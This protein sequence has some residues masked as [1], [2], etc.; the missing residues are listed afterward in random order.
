M[1]RPG[2]TVC[3]FFLHEGEDLFESGKETWFA[4]RPEPQHKL[5]ARHVWGGAL[6]PS[7]LPEGSEGKDDSTGQ[8]A[9]QLHLLEDFVI[10]LSRTRGQGQP[11]PASS[12]STYR[13]GEVSRATKSV[14]DEQGAA[15]CREGPPR[16][17]TLG[18]PPVVEAWEGGEGGFTNDVVQGEMGPEEIHKP[19]MKGPVTFLFEA[20]GDVV[21]FPEPMWELQAGVTGRDQG[22][23]GTLDTVGP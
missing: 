19:P 20:L 15:L 10:L 8:G 16:E 3:R 14:K 7:P 6:P 18:Q 13:R 23:A 5:I 2:Q 17:V 9:L 22:E 11:V 21:N 1:N 12:T 4:V